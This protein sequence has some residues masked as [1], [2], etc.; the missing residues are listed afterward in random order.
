MPKF[1]FM[2]DR[3][4][5]CFEIFKTEKHDFIYGVYP[6]VFQA[7]MLNYINYKSSDKMVQ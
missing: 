6:F 3:D 1:R 7:E 2:N 4:G 5:K